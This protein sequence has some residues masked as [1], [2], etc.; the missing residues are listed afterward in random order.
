MPLIGDVTRVNLSLFLRVFED[1]SVSLDV[2]DA[3][4]SDLIGLLFF[5]HVM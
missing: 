3:L 5:S 2:I 1:F 4:V